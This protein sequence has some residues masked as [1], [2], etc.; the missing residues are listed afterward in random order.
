[1]T[2]Q[3]GFYIIAGRCVECHA[4]EVACKELNNVAL[5][6]SWRRVQNHWGGEFPT[7]TSFNM[8]SA[9]MHC[10]KPA[11]KEV[12]PTGAITKRAEDGIVLVNQSECIACHACSS[13]CPYGVPQY[14]HDGKMQKCDLCLDR[15]EKGKEPVC[16]STCPGEA[17]GFAPV[18]EFAKSAAGKLSVRLEGDTKP[19]FFVVGSTI[20]PKPEVFIDTFFRRS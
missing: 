4:C 19:S 7:P 9:C 11:C 16:V 8:S 17:L 15:L 3:L 5:G 1:M 13:A 10:E 18:E 20:G 6:I 2:K 14:G 12:C